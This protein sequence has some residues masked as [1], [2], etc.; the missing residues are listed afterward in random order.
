M[1]PSSLAANPGRQAE[2]PGCHSARSTRKPLRTNLSNTTS[3]LAQVAA[4]SGFPIFDHQLPH[5]TTCRLPFHHLG[6]AG[7]T[8][9]RLHA[10]PMPRVADHR[11]CRLD[12]AGVPSSRR[13]PAVNV[14]AMPPR[15]TAPT[16]TDPGS[17]GRPRPR[18]GR[19]RSKQHE[20]RSRQGLAP[21]KWAPSNAVVRP[22][23]PNARCESAFDPSGHCATRVRRRVATTHQQLALHDNPTIPT[24]CEAAPSKLERLNLSHQPNVYFDHSPLQPLITAAVGAPGGSGPEAPSNDGRPLPQ[25]SA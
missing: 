13:I 6:A 9:M 20:L 5:V 3:C 17:Y 11:S 1:R 18:G 12:P 24:Y 22:P 8:L 2:P 21:G 14:V 10:S 23:L 7:P 4:T 15:L 16:H 19:A 25:R